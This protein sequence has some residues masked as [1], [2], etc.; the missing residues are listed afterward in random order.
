MLR[1]S[2]TGLV[3]ATS[4]GTVPALAQGGATPPDPV[5]TERARAGSLL[6][7]QLWADDQERFLEQWNQP[8]PPNLTNTTSTRR[9]DPVTMF[10]I[11]AG[12]TPNAEGNC[13][14]T[15]NVEFTDP[16]GLP[17]GTGHEFVVSDGP[18][19]PKPEL[20]VLS[21]ASIGLVIEDG[22]KLGKY[23]VRLSVTDQVAG[24]TAVTEEV[25]AVTEAAAA[26]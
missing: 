8:T 5:L 2:I 16:D 9:N 21:P 24:V 3:L 18:A 23:R 14:L 10:I 20:L 12:C 25:L 22:E 6:V 4:L 26:G 15:G 11:F 17:Y 1:K 19:G 13:R 7:L